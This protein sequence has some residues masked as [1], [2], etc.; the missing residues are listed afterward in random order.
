MYRCHVSVSMFVPMV[1]T[2]AEAVATAA[3]TMGAAVVTTP[4]TAE[5]ETVT[6]P[7]KTGVDA[8]PVNTGRSL[9]EVV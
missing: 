2:V 7:M 8:S 4:T 9:V 6:S 5:K 3:V 1:V